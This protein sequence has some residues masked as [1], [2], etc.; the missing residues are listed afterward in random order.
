MEDRVMLNNSQ[1]KKQEVENHR[2]NVKFSKNKRSVT[3]CNDSLKAKTSNVNFVCDTCGK[4]VLNEKHDMCVLKSLNGVKSRTKMPIVVPVITREPKRTVN[5]SVAKP[6][7]KTVAS[8]STNQK[9]RHTT[10]KLY[11]HI[12][13]ACRWWYPKFTPPGYKW[14]PKSEIGNVNPNVSMPLG[15]ASRTANILEP[16][17]PRHSTV[18]N[19]TL[20]SNSFAARRDYPIHRRLWVLKAY[21]GKSQ[22]SN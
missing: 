8:E 19:T 9:P 10:K 12:S 14:K 21:D 1:G 13:K 18:S 15:N 22:A 17:T 5:Q 3:A 11:E 6:L 16:I 20:Y 4:C 7:R 2:R